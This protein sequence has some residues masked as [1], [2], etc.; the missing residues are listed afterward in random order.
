MALQEHKSASNW[1]NPGGKSPLAEANWQ[2][3][4]FFLRKN[5]RSLPFSDAFLAAICTGLRHFKKWPNPRSKS[6]SIIAIWQNPAIFRRIFG[7][8]LQFSDEFLAGSCQKS[9]ENWQ[10]PTTSPLQGGLATRNC[11]GIALVEAG[12]P[13]AAWQAQNDHRPFTHEQNAEYH[14][15]EFFI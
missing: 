3:P 11:P 12:R 14:Q 4:A 8:I 9:A 13:P 2:N 15:H 1:A 5:G 6:P 7:R 10:D